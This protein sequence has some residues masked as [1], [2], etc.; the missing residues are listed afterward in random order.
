MSVTSYVK[1]NAASVATGI[2]AGVA[3]RAV[4]DFAE[5][6]RRG[7]TGSTS[8]INHAKARGRKNTEILAYPFTVDEDEQQGHY[9]MFNIYL[10]GKGKL[11]TPKTAKQSATEA[12]DIMA[13]EFGVDDFRINPFAAKQAFAAST[14]EGEVGEEFNFD[15][16]NMANIVHGG[17]TNK[18]TSSFVG[19]SAEGKIN[20]SIQLSQLGPRQKQKT[21]ALYMP[22]TVDVNYTVNYADEEIGSLAMAGNEV[23]QGFVRGTDVLSKLQG[24]ISDK[25]AGIGGE[26]LQSFVENTAETFAGGAKALFELNRG[27]VITPR[28]ELMFDGVGRRSFSFTFSFIPKNQDESRTVENIIFQFKKFMMPEYSNP[29]TRREMNIPATFEI[30][31]YYRNTRNDFINRISTCFLK[32]MDVK[33]GG[34]RY[35]TY[36]ATFTEGGKYGLP[37]QK[38]TMTLNFQE[39]EILSRDHIEEG[40]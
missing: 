3:G 17:M 18:V 8:P 12:R 5:G 36:P 21:I 9:I 2:A 4:K 35:T 27:T 20:R 30:D 19:G 6:V 40:Y 37:P 34:D 23:I 25:V 22:P 14:E 15:E 29:E 10:H 13:A 7:I 16:S 32:T 24:M 11:V 26:A 39:L 28:M 31:Y 33:Y 38:S 1:F